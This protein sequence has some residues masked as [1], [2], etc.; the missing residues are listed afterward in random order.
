MGNDAL[1]VNPTNNNVSQHITVRG[2]DWLWAVFCIMAFTDLVVI[3]W[4]FT[5]PRGQRVFHQLAAIVLTTASIAVSNDG[6]KT[7]W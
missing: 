6:W 2:S 7:A 3:V 4:H 1:Q 5:I